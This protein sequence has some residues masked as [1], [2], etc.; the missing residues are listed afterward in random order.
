MDNMFTILE[1]GA[2][3]S[4]VV[5]VEGLMGWLYIE[6]EHEVTRYMQVFEH[7]RNLALNPRETIE[8]MSQ[9][10]SQYN[11]VSPLASGDS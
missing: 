1:F 3:A 8:L 4:R 11:R 5:Y 2:V 7:L 10:G 9:I 6:R